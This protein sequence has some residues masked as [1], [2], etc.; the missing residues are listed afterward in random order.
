MTVLT[1]NEDLHARDVQKLFVYAVSGKDLRLSKNSSTVEC[2]YFTEQMDNGLY[3]VIGA[4]E[5]GSLILDIQS[6]PSGT[7]TWTTDGTLTVA[8]NE[9]RQ[10]IYHTTVPINV[11]YISTPDNA[12]TI[13]AAA[14]ETK[15]D[16][17]FSD[18][19]NNAFTSITY[20]WNPVNN[21]STIFSNLTK[22]NLKIQIYMPLTS[23]YM[24][25]LSFTEHNNAPLLTMEQKLLDDGIETVVEGTTKMK[26]HP[27]LYSYYLNDEPTQV[28]ADA[29][30]LAAMV[31]KALDPEHSGNAAVT[32][33][34]GSH[35]IIINRAASFLEFVTYSS[36]P[37]DRYDGGTPI[38]D[39][40][41][42][43][44]FAA[45]LDKLSV[46]DHAE[47]TSKRFTDRQTEAI[48]QAFSNDTHWRMP[49]GKEV[50]A[51][52]YQL[53]AKGCRPISYF[54]YQCT[55]GGENLRGLLKTDYTHQANMAEAK[56]VNEKLAGWMDVYPNLVSI[57][58]DT[59][60]NYDEIA[61]ASGSFYAQ[62]F[63]VTSAFSATRTTAKAYAGLYSGALSASATV[64]DQVYTTSLDYLPRYD[65]LEYSVRV[66]DGGNATQ[67]YQ[68]GVMF[69]KSD[70]SFS[71]NWSYYVNPGSD[72]QKITL[73]LDDC[74]ESE[75]YLR[76]EK[77]F[78]RAYNPSTY[79]AYNLDDVTLSYNR[80]AYRPG[81]EMNGGVVGDF[82][83]V[84]DGSQYIIVVNTDVNNEQIIPVRVFGAGLEKPWKATD[85]DNGEVFI[86][87]DCGTYS[88]LY[89][90]IP[91]G[92]A[93]LLKIGAVSDG[94]VLFLAKIDTIRN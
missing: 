12:S 13:T 48:A 23:V 90:Q 51:L 83:S 31:V 15:L 30:Q 10:L 82:V 92:S 32:G 76:V 85:H 52:I 21:K 63:E 18:L 44:P 11:W 8:A 1:Q 87:T 33:N 49:V 89:V 79:V 70:G 94:C 41:Q 40:S 34:H 7:S 54:I 3:A 80:P 68:L 84:V 36:Y 59:D 93:R 74:A 17:D 57:N 86:L 16:T 77:F 50:S 73:N 64:H 5:E 27:Q 35:E 6:A 69:M 28:Q 88:M 81:W 38:G 42:N 9:H 62:G 75:D 20:M 67:V 91:K 24:D 58:S 22:Y 26:D 45:N 25:G 46:V 65:G 2:D 19:T 78:F 37:F 56:I 4:L 60:V 47:I 14:L 53:A 71:Q 66:S 55:I 29:L 43:D 72:W 39:F 61:E